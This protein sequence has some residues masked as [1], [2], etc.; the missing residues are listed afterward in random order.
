[1]GVSKIGVPQNGWFIMESL[2]KMDDLGVLLFSETSICLFP[3]WI[4]LNCSSKR[5][6][7]CY[8]DGVINPIHI[9]WCSPQLPICVRPL[10]KGEP[11]ITPFRIRWLLGPRPP[12]RLT[13]KVNFWG[14]VAFFWSFQQGKGHA[15]TWETDMKP[16]PVCSWFEIDCHS[17]KQNTRLWLLGNN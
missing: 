2:I 7:T 3:E 13:T 16:C 6:K 9:W 1:M 14:L 12:K 4:N 17:G 15:I 5:P 8:K 10:K 11:Y